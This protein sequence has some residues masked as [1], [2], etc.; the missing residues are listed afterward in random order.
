MPSVQSGGVRTGGWF[1]GIR[2]RHRGDAPRG[3][4]NLALNPL[5]ANPGA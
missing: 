3:R 1:S 5:F 4:G 2:C